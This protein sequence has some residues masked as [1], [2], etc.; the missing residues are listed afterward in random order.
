L[1][2]AVKV[3]VKNDGYIKIGMYADVKLWNLLE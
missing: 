2:Y 1:V 3:M